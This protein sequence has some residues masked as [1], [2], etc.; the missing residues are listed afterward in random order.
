MKKAAAA[1]TDIRQQ[2][3]D[4]KVE[5]MELDLSRLTSVQEFAMAYRK[6]HQTLNLLINNAGIMFPPIAKQ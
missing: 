3:P 6:R 1:A 2:I 5:T 4:A